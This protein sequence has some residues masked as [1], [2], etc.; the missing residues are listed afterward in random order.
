MTSRNSPKSRRSSGR[1]TQRGA[2][3]SPSCY[4][5]LGKVTTIVPFLR[6]TCIPCLDRSGE[7]H[8]L[9]VVAGLHLAHSFLLTAFR[10]RSRQA[11]LSV[12]E[13]YVDVFQ[14][15]IGQAK[16]DDVFILLIA[17]MDGGAELERVQTT[18]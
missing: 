9:F 1:P 18:R 7:R 6:S 5:A 2:R 14:V 17:K 10:L 12:P 8:Q 15:L 4:Q 11:Q 13:F 16:M 3:L